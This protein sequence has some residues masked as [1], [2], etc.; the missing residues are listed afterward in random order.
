MLRFCYNPT[1]AKLRGDALFKYFLPKRDSL[2]SNEHVQTFRKSFGRFYTHVNVFAIEQ[3]C[4][5]FKA[6]DYRYGKD[7]R[8][9]AYDTWYQSF[10]KFRAPS[11]MDADISMDKDLWP[12]EIQSWH[13]G[14]CGEAPLSLLREQMKQAIAQ[15][16]GQKER[17]SFF[18]IIDRK[19]GGRVSDYVDNFFAHSFLTNESS[20][21]HHKKWMSYKSLQKDPGFNFIWSCYAFEWQLIHHD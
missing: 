3:S 17:P 9:E 19:F 7:V 21:R 15:Y 12:Q 5:K 10:V 4:R 16:A 1:C 2:P 8:S 11:E 18:R 20:L 13:D 6:K 14:F